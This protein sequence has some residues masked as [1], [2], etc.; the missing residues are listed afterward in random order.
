MSKVQKGLDK[1]F[2]G[3]EPE[4]P[5]DE[6]SGINLTS[7]YNWY[8]YTKNIDD[9]RSYL[10]EYCKK[11]DL[12]NSAALLSRVPD[13]R[14][15]MTAAWIARILSRGGVVPKSSQKFLGD[16]L[17]EMYKFSSVPVVQK[18][19][20]DEKVL[21]VQDYMRAKFSKIMADLEGM[22]DD[23]VID[24]NWSMYDY[25]RKN[26]ISTPI[27]KMI[28]EKYNPRLD[29]LVEAVAE[30]DDQVN[31][32]YSSYKKSEIKNLAVIYQNLI[33]DCNRYAEM[34]KKQRKPRKKKDVPAE[35][36]VKGLKYL[37]SDHKYRLASIN[38]SKIVGATELWTFNVTNCILSVYRAK[39][40]AGLSVKGSSIINI[41]KDSYSKRIGRKTD[42]HLQTVVSGGKVALR[43]LMDS[44]NGDKLPLTR[45][46]K[47]VILLRVI[48]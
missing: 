13:Q 8:S 27:A 12:K 31:E 47:N 22:L 34:N 14:I 32:G 42:Q 23:R 15:N 36:L 40:R 19:N 11:H 38:A 17:E 21:S 4:L 37:A 18:K 29:E 16:R 43:K 2:L 28:A 24:K 48:N 46:G 1:K 25:L 9:A 30:T 5:K 20:T 44:I 35:K 3:S 7:L 45:I 26:S 33:D 6:I 39:D 10:I 41:D